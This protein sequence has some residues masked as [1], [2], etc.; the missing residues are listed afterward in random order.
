MNTVKLSLL[1]LFIT[2]VTNTS[3]AGK[4]DDGEEKEPECDY[5]SGST[6]VSMIRNGKSCPDSGPTGRLVNNPGG[7]SFQLRDIIWRN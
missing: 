7:Y 2:A 5:I 1:F 3:Y 4:D 6:K